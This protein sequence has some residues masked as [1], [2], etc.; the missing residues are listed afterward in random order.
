MRPGQAKTGPVEFSIDYRRR[1]GTPGDTA[2]VT[3]DGSRLIVVDESKL[4]QDVG[5]IAKIID[6]NRGAPANNSQRLLDSLFDEDPLTYA[7]LDLKGQGTGA[8]LQFDFGSKRVRL[9]GVELLARPKYR[10]RTA[11]ATVQGSN[12]GETWTTLSEAAAA[13]EDWQSLQ[14]KPSDVSYRHLRIFNRN[15]WHCNVSEVRFHGEAK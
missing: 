4:I 11:G 6:P 9:S 10:D 15:N 3:T 7:E 12:D 14:M 2:S 8:Y 13:T 1:D 5:Q